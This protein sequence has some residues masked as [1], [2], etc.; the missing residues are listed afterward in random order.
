MPCRMWTKLRRDSPDHVLWSPSIQKSDEGGASGEE[1]H[2]AGSPRGGRE[3]RSRPQAMAAA[4]LSAVMTT[5][6][7]P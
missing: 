5:E 2:K 6:K 4:E 3:H 1:G 7:D